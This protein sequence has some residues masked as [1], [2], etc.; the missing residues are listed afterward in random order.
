MYTHIHTPK[1]KK[2]LAKARGLESR[3]NWA[4]STEGSLARIKACGMVD[5]V[6]S[7]R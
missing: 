4:N 3:T 5:N 7:L 1:K 6:K 2:N